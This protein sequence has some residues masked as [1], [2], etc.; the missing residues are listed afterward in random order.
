MSLHRLANGAEV[1]VLSVKDLIA[2]PIWKNNRIID[3]S[4]VANIRRNVAS[5]RHLDHGFHIAHLSEE[6]AGG[7]TVEQRY[8][9]DGQHRACV[10]RIHFEE[11][12][13][14]EP[15]SVLVFER[16]FTTEGELIEYFNALNACKPVQPW[17]DENLIINN[18]VR[19]LEEVFGNLRNRFLRPGMCHR[20]YLSVDKLREA[21]RNMK[22]LPATARDAEAFAGRVKAWNDA[23]I[24]APPRIGNA[25]RREFFEKGTR[26]GFV[27]AYDEKF[28]W[29]EACR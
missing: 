9:I 25:K 13:G 12:P 3:H 10:L 11:N 26:L 2:T 1:R 14:T 20:P 16:R 27:L 29:I 19:A 4:H 18:Y 15:F 7:N 24:L 5:I 23:C 6:D 17:T 8:I 21:L 28:P 22:G